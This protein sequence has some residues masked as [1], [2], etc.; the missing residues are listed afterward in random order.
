MSKKKRV[1]SGIQPTGKLHLGNLLGA[2]ENWKNLQKE[3]ECFFFI[4]DYHALTTLYDNPKELSNIITDVATDLL[5]VGIDPNK[6]VLFKQ[7]DVPE[8]AEL[9]LLLSMIT[10][11]AWV[12]RVPSYKSKIKEIQGKD[13]GTYGF[14]G[15]PVLQAADILIYKADAV[16]VGE[17]QL[18]HIELTREIGR[19][20]NN[21]YGDIF[22][23]PKSLLTKIPNVPGLDGRKMSKSYNNTIDLSD[24]E[25]ELKKKVNMM[26]TDPARITK[27]DKGHP[28]VC[29]AFAFHKMFN[30][31]AVE[32]I[33]SECMGAERGCVECKKE[34]LKHLG[35]YLAPIQE[36]RAKIK[37]VDAVL[38]DGAIK[39][40]KVAAATLAEVKAAM[41]LL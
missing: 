39:A 12:Q 36:R 34:L 38:A 15:Y 17:D 31:D 23:F 29:T 26:I 5:S 24:S 22:P 16:P 19:R 41:G 9:H 25:S 33:S 10:P 2:L 8:H 6:S 21:F 20:F 1:L 4:A 32:T 13:L 30:K 27:K 14:L 3:F 37:D 35:E 7:S 28:D 18:P 11:L 40:K